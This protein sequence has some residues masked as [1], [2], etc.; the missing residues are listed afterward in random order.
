MYTTR[1]FQT[2][3]QLREAIAR[4]DKIDIF[5]PG[6]G[7]PKRNGTEYIEGPHSPRP[8]TWHA[9]VEMLGGYIKRIVS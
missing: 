3:K 4:G 8:H 1:D 6:M 2:K 5:A 7:A 9:Q